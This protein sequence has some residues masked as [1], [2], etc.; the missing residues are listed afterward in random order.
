[1]Q[2]VDSYSLDKLSEDIA[3][4]IKLEGDGRPAILVGHD[5]GGAVCWATAAQHPELISKLVIACAPHP[6]CFSRNFDFDQ[7]FRSWYMFLFQLPFLPELTLS[8]GDFAFLD[9][10]L[11]K[12]P[13]AL[14]RQ[15]ALTQE[16]VDRYKRELSRP[17]AL[18]ASLNYYRSSLRRIAFGRRRGGRFGGSLDVGD[19]LSRALRNK[20]CC[21]TLVLWADKDIALGRQLLRGT[22]RYVENLRV[23]I[24]EDCS[25]WAQQDRPVE[26]NEAVQEFLWE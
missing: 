19:Q 12:G 18:H 2:G 23:K 25:H 24:L 22:E 20:I 9:E 21:P 3:A 15:G 8:A 14:R 11:L 16:D 26:F 6:Y 7:F 1:M 5:W 17:G 13:A 4:V 10:A